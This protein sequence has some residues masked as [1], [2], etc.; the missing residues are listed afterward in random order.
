MSDAGRPSRP[1]T[2]YFLGSGNETI[3]YKINSYKPQSRT[4]QLQYISFFGRCYLC[5]Y[6]GH[7]QKYCPLR[8]CKHCQ[9][10]GHSEHVCWKTPLPT[11]R[12]T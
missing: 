9:R 2:E 12:R 4:T 8:R 6:Q 1:A 10:Y 11:D 7:S 3:Q 5:K